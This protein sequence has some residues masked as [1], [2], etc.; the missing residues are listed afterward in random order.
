MAEIQKKLEALPFWAKLI[1][2]IVLDSYGI[3]KRFTRGDTAGIILGVLQALT[4]NFVGIMW[5]ID[6]VTM[7]AKK[8]VTILAK[9]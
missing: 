9:A 1:C 5:I 8:E 7:I 3:V 4:C 6:I 2:V